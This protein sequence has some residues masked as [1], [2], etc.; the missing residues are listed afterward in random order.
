MGGDVWE[1]L[2]GLL[3][4]RGFCRPD[5]PNEIVVISRDP[6]DWGREPLK[7]LRGGGGRAS[8]NFLIRGRSAEVVWNPVLD[9]RVEVVIRSG[10]KGG[11]VSFL[12]ARQILEEVEAL[13]GIKPVWGRPFPRGSC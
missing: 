7:G 5:A 2:E 12:E 3:R 6:V 11:R 10:P 1:F 8:M 9:G 13:L 4:S